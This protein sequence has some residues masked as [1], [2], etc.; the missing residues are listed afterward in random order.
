MNARWID[1]IRRHGPNAAVLLLIAAMGW[2]G[3][4]SGWKVSRLSTLWSRSA[5]VEEDWC[6]THNVPLSKCIS[7][8]PALR[9]ANPAD[10]C[11]EHGMPESRC[12]FCHPDILKSGKAVDWCAQ[13]GVPESQCTICHP[14]IAAKGPPPEEK[15]DVT[16]LPPDSPRAE[17]NP[18]SCSIHELRVQFASVE[19]VG[20]AGIRLE[21]VEERP[22]PEFVRAPGEIQ[23]GQDAVA[24]LSAR[25]PGIAWRILK[26]LGDWVR[27]GDVLALVACAE[28]GRAR[29][30]LIQALATR[31]ARERTFKR[32][33]TSAESGFRTQG[34]LQEAEASV[35]AARIQVM[36][37]EQAL[38][39]LGLPV[40]AED[41]T[42]LPDE[43]LSEEVRF[44]GLTDEIRKALGKD[45]TEG[46]LL[47]MVSPIEGVVVSRE[48]VVGEAVDS[49]RTLFVVADTGRMCVALD[50]R[51]EDASRLSVG[52][53][54]IFR[55]D[56]DAGAAASG[57]V[58]W[59]GTAVDDRTRTVKAR[60]DLENPEGRLLAHT[61]GSARVK[62]R[63]TPNAAVVPERAIQWEGCCRIVFVR[64]TPEIFQPRKVRLGVRNGEFREILVGLVPGEVVVTEGSALLKSEI[65][66]SRLGV[67]CAGE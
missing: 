45:A 28:A 25:S 29:A 37:A 54:V 18:A 8:T 41:L 53:D 34:E 61:F 16:V 42:G 14:D 20:K 51:L 17:R 10:W 36:A 5:P 58:T 56:G 64:Q 33:E 60:A 13:H 65:L 11:K 40:R 21:T 30:D 4:R 27:K 62:V 49:T 66:K 39:N 31:E 47:P 57:K 44:L 1:R 55:P 26:G 23:Y 3:H 19:S 43:R 6:P 67:G 35:H 24:R 46:G 22:M 2:W 52:Q 12:I 32:I 63:E 7:C 59:V 48:V 38:R 9:G 15:S 50:V